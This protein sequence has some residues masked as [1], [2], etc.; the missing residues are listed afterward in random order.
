MVGFVDVIGI[1]LNVIKF[2]ELGL[3]IVVIE[4][5]DV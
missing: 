3:F 2:V 5:E 4:F 1:D